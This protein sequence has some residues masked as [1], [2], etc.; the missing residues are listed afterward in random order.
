MS[1]VAAVVAL[2][3]LSIVAAAAAATRPALT[4]LILKPAQV[5][6]G[7]RVAL[8]PG[9]RQVKGQVT[10]DLCGFTFRSENLRTARIQVAYRRPG[11]AVQLSN[12]VVRYRPGGTAM[13]MRELGH[14]VA[15]CPRGP[16]PSHIKG[17][18]PL[19]YRIK[20]LR[21]S[22]LLPG[23]IVLQIHVSGTA[24]GRRV[25]ETDVVAYEVKD[26]VLSGVYTN[27]G[28]IAAQRRLD[29]HAAAESAANLRRA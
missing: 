15:H 27:G 2:A 12:E 19:V 29:A 10:L 17:V 14:A 22:G 28:T 16:V 21:F 26:N 5:G 18:G 7:Y 20:N 4:S 11:S 25:D 1:Q 3:V 24:Q 9:G 6:A 13:A 8:I 23:S